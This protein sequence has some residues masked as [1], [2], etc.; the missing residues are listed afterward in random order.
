[1]VDITVK[2]DLWVLFDL[3]RFDSTLGIY[4]GGGGV[5]TPYVHWPLV[6]VF[7]E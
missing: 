5:V 6:L 4:G 3:K 7:P 2:K 1:M